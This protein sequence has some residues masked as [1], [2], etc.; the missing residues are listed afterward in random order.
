M[1]EENAVLQPEPPASES[2]VS[3]SS[4]PAANEGPVEREHASDRVFRAIAA[5]ILNRELTAEAPLP[6]ERELSDRFGVSRIVVREAIHRLK[7]YELVRVRQ[8]SPTMVLDP[9]RATDM[10]LLGLEIELMPLSPENL[11]AFAERQIYSGAAL[12]D[13]AEQRLEPAELDQLEVITEKLALV[14]TL[15]AEWLQLDRQYWTA[16]AIGGRNRLYVR[17]TAWYF[18]LLERHPRFRAIYTTPPP[19]RAEFYRRLNTTL[20]E[21]QGSAAMYLANL[22]VV[23]P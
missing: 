22:R 9:D 7:E 19:Q 18:N 21:R 2:A 13:L 6:P 16:I 23:M 14:E 15:N 3:A 12:L 10:R 17:E 8:G 1:G 11:A 4:A 5:A 20:R